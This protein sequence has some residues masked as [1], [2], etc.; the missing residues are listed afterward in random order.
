MMTNL[1]HIPAS[2]LPAMRMRLIRR[3]I[4]ALALVAGVLALFAVVAWKWET[5]HSKEHEITFIVPPGTAVLQA[6]GK[7]D[8]MLPKQIWLVAG[9]HDTLIILNL[10]GFPVRIG[11]FKLEAGQQYRQRFRNA[12]EVLLVCTTMYH[13]EQMKILVMETKDPWRRLLSALFRQN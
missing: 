9:E 10:D 11:P 3:F 7:D 13:E 1:L 5:D 4:V 2:T 8:L 12:G 6:N